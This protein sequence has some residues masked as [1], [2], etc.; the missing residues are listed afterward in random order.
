MKKSPPPHVWV[1]KNGL[2]R[3]LM[4]LR[5]S[6]ESFGPKLPCKNLFDGN[7]VRRTYYFHHFLKTWFF[8]N[9]RN[10]QF[11]LQNPSKWLSGSFKIKKSPPPHVCGRRNR[12][13]RRTTTPFDSA[14]TH[15]PKHSLERAHVEFCKCFK[16]FYAHLKSTH[17]I[18]WR[19][20]FDDFKRIFIKILE[21][22]AKITT[23]A[24]LNE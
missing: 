4:S 2:A 19:A 8:K 1:N 16:I 20:F 5:T 7:L 13:T 22:H 10:L 15:G 18:C 14:D 17:H 11:W 6:L 12:F 23:S 24:R 9:L 21:N 3:F